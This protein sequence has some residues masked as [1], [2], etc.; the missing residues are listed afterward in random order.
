MR[1]TLALL[2]A[3][4][5]VGGGPQGSFQEAVSDSG[6]KSLKAATVLLGGARGIGT[7][8]VFRR[9]GRKVWI[10]T[11]SNIASGQGPL[12][13]VWN[14]G[15]PEENSVSMKRVAV[16]PATSMAV[17]KCELKDPPSPLVPVA[18]ARLRESQT[19]F[20]AG[21]PGGM[22]MGS[23]VRSPA[24]TISRVTVA[25]LVADQ[26]GALRI[27]QLDGQ[28]LPGHGGGPVVD[29]RGGLIGMAS[30]SVSDTRVSFAVAST[31]IT[32]L[33]EGR[34]FPPLLLG[35]SGD[36]KSVKVRITTGL[37]DPLD[38]IRQ[39]VLLLVPRIKVSDP[40]KPGDGGV[41]GPISDTAAEFP[42]KVAEGD[43]DQEITVPKGESEGGRFLAQIRYSRGGTTRWTAP[44]EAQFDFTAKAPPPKPE[45][46]PPAPPPSPSPEA[47]L[48]VRVDDSGRDAELS[49]ENGAQDAL[50]Q[51]VY[52]WKDR[53]HPASHIVSPDRK[54]LYAVDVTQDRGR[55]SGK[56]TVRM[57]NLETWREDRSVTLGR[58]FGEPQWG[59]SGLV[60]TSRQARGDSVA[61]VLDPKSLHWIRSYTGFGNELIT[62]PL[63]P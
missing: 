9:D 23:G 26:H 18:A 31:E 16:D 30:H 39:T 33:L 61:V 55:D 53:G 51:R 60:L 5:L 44:V 35:G 49:F 59:P 4:V 17:L 57:I 15:T 41:W 21:F 22:A 1:R 38:K 19:G 54:T 58:A 43:V 28:T 62:H 3:V 12:F 42:L 48:D 45:D 27:V 36:E 47:E 46:R 7:G 8:F 40:L 34:A 52:V 50:R 24:P 25:S 11:H 37:L 20:L 6:R 56:T 13:G 63:S 32:E 29:A 10:I 2:C 14:A